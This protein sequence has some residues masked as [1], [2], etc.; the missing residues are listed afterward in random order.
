MYFHVDIN[1]YFATML[2]QE[3][4]SLRGKPLGILKSSGRTCVIAASLE[5]KKYGVKTGCSNFEAKKLCPNILFVPAAFNLYLSS[6]KRLNQVFASLCPK[7]HTFSLDESFLDMHGCE[8]LMHQLLGNRRT[9]DSLTHDFGR[10]VQQRIKESLGSWVQCNVGISHNRLL[11]KMA[12]EIGPKGG[13]FE[14]THENLNDVLSQVSFRDVCGVGYAL[15]KRLSVLGVTTP[16]QL[17]L[18]DDET[19]LSQFGPFWGAELR[20]IGKGEETWFFAKPPSFAHMQSVGRTTTGFKLCDDEEQIK[21][22]LLNLLEEATYKIRQMDLAGRGLGIF[23]SG[24]NKSWGKQLRLKYYVRHTNEI[25]NLLYHQLYRN[26]KRDFPVIRFGMFIFDLKPTSQIPLSLL[27]SFQ[28]AEKVYQAIDQVNNRFGLFTLRP[29]TLMGKVM[30]PE[31]TGYL[32]DKIFH[33]L[34]EA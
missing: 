23:L 7:V 4:P 25:F 32:G 21:K 19:L 29:A 17:N 10:L 33:G 22:I 2:Q 16:L 24:H 13:V 14:I 1:S 11:A 5:A 34:G 12:G 9:S 8:S 27:P 28:K 3:N 15:E 20:K 26:F 18:L 30:F 6:T 31:V